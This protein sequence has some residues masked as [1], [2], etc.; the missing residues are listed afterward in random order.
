MICVGHYGA[1]HDISGVSTWVAGLLHSLHASS[2]SCS[3][4]LPHFGADLE[5]CSLAVTVRDSVQD[6][7]GVQIPFEAE[8]F[9]RWTLQQLNDLEPRVFA[10]QCLPA[11]HYASRIALQQ[12]LPCVLT[13]HSDAPDY[14]ALADLMA[15]GGSRMV[16][17]AVSQFLA[18]KASALFPDVDVRC[19]P[20]GVPVGRR[21]ARWHQSRFRI[22]YCGRMLQEQKRISLVAETLIA[23]CRA[24][25]RIEGLMVGDGPHR[26]HAEEAVLQAG[27]AD[28]IRF[29]GRL[30]GASLQSV[31]ADCQALLLMSDYEG[32]PVALLEGMALGLVPMTRWSQSGIPELVKDGHSGLILPDSPVKAARLIVDRTGTESD[33]ERMSV[34][35]HSLV[36]QQY[37]LEA[38]LQKWS[39]LLKE[40]MGR[41]TVQYPLQIPRRIVLPRADF[42]LS[43][44]D[45]RR[46]NVW[47]KLAF[48]ARKVMR[49]FRRLKSI[50][51]GS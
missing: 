3:L 13:L 1:A 42:R 19:I 51:G 40:L 8:A 24:D 6:I 27:L 5:R 26:G 38:S 37:S 2:C 22:A 9:T 7:R 23:C 43:Q 36:Q 35:A 12:G 20:Y 50:D 30:E 25:S 16:W 18:D 21:S 48:R 11:Y 41:S 47:Q 46:L 49:V 39:D 14:W 29:T 44:C 31:L 32:L 28:R 33:W 4:L 45:W 10:P 17:V 34:N 15:G